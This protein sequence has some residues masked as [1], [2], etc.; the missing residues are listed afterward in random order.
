MCPGGAGHMIATLYL[1]HYKIEG[2][3]RFPK[4]QTNPVQAPEGY[5]GGPVADAFFYIETR[6]AACSRGQ[7]PTNP[8]SFTK[9]FEGIYVLYLGKQAP[10]NARF[11][12]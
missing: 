10:K 2:D 8:N 3:T 1:A 12:L 5:R 4:G 9:V 7:T 6:R 11:F